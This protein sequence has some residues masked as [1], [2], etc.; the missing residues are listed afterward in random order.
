GLVLGASSRQIPSDISCLVLYE[1]LEPN[2]NEQPIRKGTMGGNRLWAPPN[3]KNAYHRNTTP[4]KMFRWIGGRVQVPA[5]NDVSRQR[6]LDGYRYAVATIF[7]QWPDT[8]HLLTVPFDAEKR[9]VSEEPGGWKILRFNHIPRQGTQWAY[10]SS[11]NVAGDQ[12]RLAAPGS[13]L[14]M[15]QLLPKIYDYEPTLSSSQDRQSAGLIGNLPILFALAA[16][17]ASPQRLS[18]VLT[19]CMKPNRWQAHTSP[20]GRKFYC[21]YDTI[22]VNISE[23]FRGRGMVVTVFYDLANPKGSTKTNLDLLQNGYFGPFYGP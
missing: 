18:Q 4:P 7:T 20:Q 15:P 12:Q 14:H 11:V 5:S 21:Y 9:D 17:S 6:K 23:G 13:P 10:Y 8:D 2:Y 3:R 16:F 19:S 22:I 1:P